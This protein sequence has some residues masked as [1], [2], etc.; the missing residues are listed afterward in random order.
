MLFVVHN[1]AAEHNIVV[2]GDVVLNSCD[3]VMGTFAHSI[4]P[5]LPQPCPPPLLCLCANRTHQCRHTFA[6]TP[7]C[8]PNSS[9]K[10]GACPLSSCI[11]PCTIVYLCLSVSGGIRGRGANFMY[12]PLFAVQ[13]E[14]A[15]PC[16]WHRLTLVCPVCANTE[17]APVKF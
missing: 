7:L 3:D 14:G 8:F 2:V 17:K 5:L 4:C 11:V 9:V 13:K 6:H 10:E 12:G 1:I 16:I 15:C